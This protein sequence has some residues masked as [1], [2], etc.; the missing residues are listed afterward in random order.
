V[1]S[2]G[3]RPYGIKSQR[4]IILGERQAELDAMKQRADLPTPVYNPANTPSTPAGGFPLR[5]KPLSSY[6]AAPAGK[7][8]ENLYS[9]GGLGLD[10]ATMDRIEA[11]AE[12]EE[13]A[14][15]AA[16]QKEAAAAE[17]KARKEAEEM[18][19][20]YQQEVESGAYN[21]SMWAPG[22]K[23]SPPPRSGGSET[24]GST[25]TKSGKGPNEFQ[26]ATMKTAQSGGTFN[27]SKYAPANK[28]M[29]WFEANAHTH[30]NESVQQDFD[31]FVARAQGAKNAEE[32]NKVMEAAG[33][34][35]ATQKDFMEKAQAHFGDKIK[36]GPGAYNYFAGNHG[37]GATG[38]TVAGASVISMASSR[39][40]KSN[41]EL[42]SDPFR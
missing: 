22:E 39:G 1:W 27:P 30:L 8:E 18:E 36:K 10:D 15:A 35:G 21:D 13:R 40:R 34:K 23:T 41:S 29:S 12:R 32:F 16:K 38:F 33:L 17:E 26:Q 9:S 14:L 24:P 31:N 3:A 42:Y 4:E 28:D 37:W 5:D 25:E 2:A 6:R 20:T 19:A 7:I 11:A